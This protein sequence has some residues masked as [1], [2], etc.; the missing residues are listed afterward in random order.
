MLSKVPVTHTMLL[1]VESVC[2]VD[3]FLYRLCG[4]GIQKSELGYSR[5]FA[6]AARVSATPPQLP[7]VPGVRQPRSR[8][9]DPLGFSV[10]GVDLRRC[11]YLLR[12]FL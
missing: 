12:C 1:L 4:V 10:P 8:S 5:E 9:G 3:L 7:R 6:G 11:P 2:L